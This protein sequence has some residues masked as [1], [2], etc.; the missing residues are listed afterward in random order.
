VL[1]GMDV[2]KKLTPRD[3]QPGSD[4]PPGDKLINITIEEK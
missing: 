3:A 4:T 2:L 1:S